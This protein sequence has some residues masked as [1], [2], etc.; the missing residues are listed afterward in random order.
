MD[1]VLVIVLNEGLV[2]A[3]G[4]DHALVLKSEQV[5]FLLVLF[6]LLLQVD[7]GHA[8]QGFLF[9]Q[10]ILEDVLI[11]VSNLLFLQDGLLSHSHRRA[12]LRARWAP[13]G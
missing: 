2:P 6:R 8:D 13:Y 3:N 9:Q 12:P 5:D 11:Q 4:L 7:G 10:V 1:P